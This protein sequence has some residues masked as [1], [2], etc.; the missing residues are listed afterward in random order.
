MPFHRIVWIE[1][2]DVF[3]TQSNR[4]WC[5]TGETCGPLGY[6]DTE[7][8][9]HVLYSYFEYPEGNPGWRPPYEWD[10]EPPEHIPRKERIMNKKLANVLEHGADPS[11]VKESTAAFREALAASDRVLVPHGI[12]K[13]SGMIAGEP[14]VSHRATEKLVDEFFEN[15]DKQDQ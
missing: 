7:E 5:A 9:R 13:L 12:Y 4:C 6:W 14:E 8:T 1:V 2:R 10:P 11:G 3:V 15:K